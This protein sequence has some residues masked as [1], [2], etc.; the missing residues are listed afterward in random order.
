MAEENQK[1]TILSL[2]VL[3]KLKIHTSTKA[4]FKNMDRVI[5]ECFI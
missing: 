1:I 5:K 2:G 3:R 4:M